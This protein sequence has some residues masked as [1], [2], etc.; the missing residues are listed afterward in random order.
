MR[1]CDL[2]RAASGNCFACGETWR[3]I[4]DASAGPDDLCAFFGPA[5]Q[6]DCHRPGF[7]TPSRAGADLAWRAKF[8][9]PRHA[10]RALLRDAQGS[11]STMRWCCGFRDRPARPARTSPNFT[12]MADARCWRRC[13]LRSRRSTDVRAA[14]PGEFTRRAFENGKLDLTEAEGLDDLIH[15]DTDRQRRQALRQLKG[16]LGRQGA[17][18][19]GADYRGFGADRSRHRFFRRRRRARRN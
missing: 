7:R 9:A 1:G 15:A 6:R 4:G 11:R 16:L 18:L 5:A 13:S 3:Q 2:G 17:R 19:A 12:S 10:A 8:R 14:E